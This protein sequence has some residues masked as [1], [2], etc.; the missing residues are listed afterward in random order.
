MANLLNKKCVPCEE[1]VSPLSK[2]ECEKLLK[3]LKG[4]DLVDYKKISKNLQFQDF[5]ESMEFVNKVADVSERENHHP[6]IL[7]YQWNK[8]KIEIYTHAIGGLSENDFILAAKIDK[9][10]EDYGK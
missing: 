5:K 3:Q 9:V 1:G 6:D 7:I 10:L 2:E 4:W 8:V